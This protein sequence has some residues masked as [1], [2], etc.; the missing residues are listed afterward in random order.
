MQKYTLRPYERIK[1]RTSFDTIFK[2]GKRRYSTYLG[3]ITLNKKEGYVRL[4]IIIGKKVGK[5]HIR[6][7]WKRH[8]R[9]FFRLNKDKLEI[10]TDYLFIVKKEAK[11][12][13]KKDI[14]ETVIKEIKTLTK[15]L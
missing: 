13:L 11:E 4:G 15:I 8:I 5:S 2:Y 7:T 10:T 3:L 12:I 9:E 14:R 6:N 1:K